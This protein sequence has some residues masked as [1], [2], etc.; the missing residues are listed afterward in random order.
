MNGIHP[1]NFCRTQDIWDISVAQ[2]PFRRPY[3]NMFIGIAHM[4]GVGIRFRINGHGFNAEFLTGPDYSNS[5]LSPIGYQN[6]FKH[7]IASPP[8]DP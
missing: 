7:P 8:E 2:S 3:T 1:G 4:Q 6:F 5:N